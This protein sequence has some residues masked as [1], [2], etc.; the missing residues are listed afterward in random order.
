[1]RFDVLSWLLPR[2]QAIAH[3]GR[4]LAQNPS[5]ESETAVDSHDFTAKEVG[6]L[7]TITKQQTTE[8][9]QFW[10]TANLVWQLAQWGAGLSGFFHSCPIHGY[11][12]GEASCA[13]CP[14]KGRMAV[15][16]A[17]GFWLKNFSDE[18]INWP[19]GPASDLLAQLPGELSQ[20]LIRDF[21]DCKVAMVQRFQQVYGFWRQIPWRLCAIGMP[22]FEEDQPRAIKASK[23]FCLDAI[24]QWHQGSMRDRHVFRMCQKF[25]DPHFPGSLSVEMEFWA[26]SGA[27]TLPDLLALELMKYCSALTTMQRLEAQHHY[28][29]QHL[30]TGRR[31]LPASICAFLRRRAN[32]DLETPTFRKHVDRY[33][34]QL[35]RLVAVKWETR[36]VPLLHVPGE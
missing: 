5:S 22:L 24:D 7:A 17:Q 19:P 29:N 36:S 35:D 16:L 14:W 31:S 34:L 26:R 3:L 1:M 6:L 10:A 28:L 23:A 30:A 9:L 20:V 25:L 27:E 21:S 15:K 11:T 18:L 12:K 32:N 2:R 13:K 33:I 8:S 4:D